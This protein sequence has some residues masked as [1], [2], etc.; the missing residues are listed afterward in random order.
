MAENVENDLR[1]LKRKRW[2]EMPSNREESRFVV[3]GT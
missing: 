3:K 1:E 2:R